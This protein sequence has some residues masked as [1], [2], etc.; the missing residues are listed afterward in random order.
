MTRQRRQVVL[1]TRQLATLIGAGI[2]LLQSLQTL[3]ATQSD[4]RLVA[5]LQ[6]IRADV[7]TG[8][9]LSIALAAHPTHFDQL[10]CNLVQVGE[11]T[12]RLDVLL[13]QLASH[14]EKIQALQGRVR[15]AM[16]Y[17][18]AVLAAASVSMAVILLWVVPTFESIFAG[19]GAELPWATQLVVGASRLLIDHGPGLLLAM[20]VVA[21]MLRRQYRRS[22]TLRLVFEEALL[23]LP[24]LGPLQQKAA[25]GRW[26]RT[27]S[28][29]LAAGVTLSEGLAT[30]ANGL[31]PQRYL[32]ATRWVQRKVEHG[33]SLSH[34][35]AAAECFPP[36]VLQMASSGEASGT[37]DTLLGRAA[38]ELERAV[39]DTVS[40]LATLLEPA[41]MLVLGLGIGGMIVALYLP[42]FRLGSVMA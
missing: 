13:A 7:E 2:P 31:G 17:P 28:T 33:Q 35:L 6:R 23:R 40:A 18:A 5:V 19:L 9:P 41:V 36:M 42:V 1:L 8:H 39:D 22:A 24:V 20:V 32:L 30:L 25:L 16:V 10:S 14:Q 34:S 11:T 38:D 21:A 12:G 26:C 37:L 29:L 15:S 4:A 3:T 27:L